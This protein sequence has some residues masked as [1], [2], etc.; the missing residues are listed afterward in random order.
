[1]SEV[2]LNQVSDADIAVV[3]MAVRFPGAPDLESY[4]RLLRDGQ[5]ALRD[6]D[7]DD[8]LAAGEDPALLSD[9]AYVKRGMLLDGHD[10]WDATFFNFSPRDAAIMDPQH[11]V[12]LECAWESL[13]HA[14]HPPSRF[15][16]AIGVFAGSGMNTYMMYNVMTNPQLVK[17]VGFFLLRHTGNDKDFL[18][19]RV[20][21]QFDLKG[22]SVNVQTACSTSLV[23]V[24]QAAQS[25]LLGECDLAL[26]GGVTIECPHGKGYL[27][28]DGEI[29]SPDGH[30]RAF[31]ARSKGTIF[32][33]GAGVVVLRRLRD[34]L[35]DGDT[36]HA[37]VRG[38][39]IN[40]DGSGKVGYLA[41]SVEG[42]AAA[43]SEALSVAD[44]DARE[45][46]YV[47]C[48]GTGTPVGDPIEVKAFTEAY[49]QHTS[50]T[51]YC[52]I[53]SVK[54]NI[55][56]LDTAAG[57][58]SFIKAVLSLK[59]GRR[60]PTL[61]FERPN[62][63][64]EIEETPFYV[65]SKL[66]TWEVPEGKRRLA[67]VS[68]LGVG[69]TNAHV[70]LEEPLEVSS[71]ESKREW[72]LLVL[73]AKTPSALD[74][75][76][77]NCRAFVEAHPEVSLD[78]LVYTYQVGRESFE[79]RRVLAFTTREE[80][81][82]EL[83]KKDTQ[84][85]ISQKRAARD[86]GVAFLF[87]GGGAQYPDMGRELYRTEPVYREVVDR[88]F[89]ILKG[90]LDEDLSELL[91]PAPEKREEAAA[92]LQRP[93][94]SILTIFITEYALAKLWQSWG[95]EPVA[96]T[97]HSLG[98]YTAACLAEV[99][100]LEDSLALVVSR[101]KV[102][103]RMPE[104][105]MVSVPL[106]EEEVRPLLTEGL[107]I[108]AINS[109]EICA[110]SGR[111]EDLE[112]LEARLAEREVDFKRI[113]ISVA[114]HSPMLDPFL[115]EF[116]A[117][118]KSIR[119][120]PAKLPYI[121]NLTGQWVRPGDTP[122]PDYWVRHL[123]QTVRFSDGLAE[124]L[125]DPSQVLLEVGPGSTLSSL[126]RAH[127]EKDREQGVVSSL[128][129]PREEVHDLQF[130]VTALGRLWM[131]GAAID[132]KRYHG[133]E[134]RLRIPVPT[135]PFERQRYFIEPGE[136]RAVGA[137]GEMELARV[138]DLDRWFYTP[139]WRLV[140]HVAEPPGEGQRWLVFADGT[141]L[142]GELVRRLRDRGHS[143]ITVHE[144]DTFYRFED[145]S[146]SITP[147]RPEEYEALFRELEERECLPDRILHLWLVTD[148]EVYRPGSSFFH[149]NLE[150]GFYS[151]L[152]LAQ[153]FGDDHREQPV[154]LT[155]VGNGMQRIRD[156]GVPYPEK[157]AALGPATVIPREFPGVTCETLDID[158]GFLLKESS[159][160]KGSVALDRFV[161][162][163]EVARPDEVAAHRE[164]GRLIRTF[165]SQ[166]QGPLEE[167]EPYRR[168]RENG[169][170]LITGGLGGIGLAQAENLARRTRARL[171]LISRSGLPPRESWDQWLKTHGNRD[172]VSHRILKVRELEELGAEVAVFRADVANIEEMEQAVRGA[173]ER[174]GAIHGVIHAAGVLDDGLI[175]VKSQADVEN[176]FASKIHGTRILDELLE[177]DS[178]DFMVLFSSTSSFLGSAGQV[179]Y[180]AA[181]AYLNAF[182]AARGLRKPDCLTVAVCWGIWQD[183]GMAQRLAA[184]DDAK[185]VPG[186]V[187]FER[188]EHPLL[189]QRI[190]DTREEVV[191]ATELSSEDHWV[192]D[193]HRTREGHAVIPG[194][195]YLEMA[196]AALAADT[197]RAVEIRDLFFTSPLQ[198]PDGTVR[199]VRVTLRHE[200][201]GSRFEVASK[202][203]GGSSGTE[204]WMP[205]V[206]GEVAFLEGASPESC[207]RAEIAARLDASTVE[208][209]S[210]GI[211]TGQEEHLRFG[212]RWRNLMRV[213]FGDH[214]ALGRLEL[215]ERFLS[216]LEEYALHPAVL[217]LATGFA[218]PLIEGYENCDDLYVP[219]QY[220]R[221]RVHAPLTPR[222]WSHVRGAPDNHVDREL[223]RFDVTIFD[224]DGRVLVEVEDF[225]IKRIGPSSAFGAGGSGEQHQGGRSNLSEQERQFQFLL[226]QGIRPEEGTEALLRII[227]KARSSQVVV[228]SVPLEALIEQA[229]K[230]DENEAG[231]EKFTRPS[232][233]S[234]Y[235]APRD[236]V[237][238]AFV[239]IWEDLLGVDQ[240]GVQD[241]FFELGGYSLIAVRLF[242]QV[243]KKFGIEFPLS[244]LFE[245]PTIEKCAALVKAQIGE[246]GES[247]GE[248][249]SGSGEGAMRHSLLV[250]LQP[251][252]GSTKPPLFMV[253][254]MFG[255]IMNL[256]HIASH[257]E[258]DQPFFGIQA[259]GL[260]GNE[261]P[262]DRFEDM[263]RDYIE[264]I[265]TVQPHGPYFLGGFS[266]GGVTA[267]E[268]A[269]QL[270]EAGEEVALVVLLD[271]PATTA[272]TIDWKDKIKLHWLKLKEH[273]VGY[274]RHWKR[275]REKWQRILQ[276]REKARADG[277]SAPQYRSQVIGD[278]FIEAVHAYQPRVYEGRVVL[279]RP[280]L[281]ERYVLGPGRV[282]NEDRNLIT[283]DNHWGPYLPG[284]LEIEMVTGDHDSMVLEPNVRVLVSKLNRHLREAQK[285]AGVLPEDDGDSWKG[286]SSEGELTRGV[287]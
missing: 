178:L 104:G 101:G 253:A 99:M 252:E 157:A 259:R 205:H 279:I 97:G 271:T 200:E 274:Y 100:S 70:I 112:Q 120:S 182:A 117:V 190:V 265:R 49:R 280:P 237:E 38:S 226:S 74:Q 150:R 165:E 68:S 261:K 154:H 169:V 46:G 197:G 212:A 75:A 89:E 151:L 229:R 175:Q 262:H 176:V 227:E 111:V 174:F 164:Q 167:D 168:L 276:E 173:R 243:K 35:E 148:R 267:Y 245:A 242:N 170:T 7:D 79:H 284:G 270:R 136:V 254:G 142:G 41:P 55:G 156:E 199:E 192:L 210:D 140:D 141:P 185:L 283:L 61:N 208:E 211:R 52:G 143:V 93:L 230:V 102:F 247:A 86:A 266:G 213:E 222:V 194:T 40:N 198:V 83:E 201:S 109:P 240:I 94:N 232:L 69:G 147:E 103:E 128:R 127:P 125:R 221:V 51:G 206:E 172:S 272:P 121:S 193:Q 80:L 281:Q 106:S 183:V 282:L 88:C 216:D 122:E 37:V 59:T 196:R 87:P 218:M 113:K 238:T 1:M 114:A 225:E 31:D 71:V 12:F 115:E 144:G 77:E 29:L 158:L 138:A 224:D 137:G 42:H 177:E 130:T 92:S 53:G 129:H 54:T 13:E 5:E 135:Y 24:H 28:V 65:T 255:N 269:Q 161:E 202:I 8:L 84:R 25:L 220:H 258:D 62:P 248:G 22:P 91:F 166:A 204:T 285:S 160:K 119:L 60:F 145:D 249:E 171:A 214:E 241:D 81:L 19:T 27:Y 43:I 58:A 56:H 45:I 153:A 95:I 223:A 96:M 9:P 263:A 203:E 209:D 131:A 57:I 98:E 181:N 250:P 6:L 146:Y 163:I 191:F 231:G 215:P 50:D 268:M 116:G 180:A 118:A 124:L 188:A 236:E 275:E 195:A 63:I 207:S 228:S 162:E 179:D 186:Q 256:R 47:E 132:W 23:A 264:E 133:D 286:V 246:P 244:V 11:R 17:S 78:D 139:S 48:H 44:V 152:F 110:V 34:A 64:L 234:E 273:G 251:A 126:A 219:I 287:V 72:H 159:Q 18:T 33:S 155:V 73:S 10:E 189:L 4:H 278:A 67:G 26:A 277:G 233:A 134:K 14:G 90:Q 105:G 36:I 184:G 85:L 123:R 32:G 260:L 76:T 2:D 239:E 108:A 107:S 20:S 217:D 39:A 21:Y 15:P 149:R 16:G 187:D 235:L 3:G 66:E 82:E 257:L 30:C